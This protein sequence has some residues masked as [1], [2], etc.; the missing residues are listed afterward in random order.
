MPV[1]GLGVAGMVI[2]GERQAE[3]GAHGEL[4]DGVP[5]LGDLAAGDPEDMHFGP[6]AAVAGG[7]P[8]RV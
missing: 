6:A 2:R 4:A 3:L 7:A 1:A 5:V 8:A